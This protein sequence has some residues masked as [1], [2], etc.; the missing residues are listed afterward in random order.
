[1][2]SQPV[3][4]NRV[5][6]EADEVA[7]L[8]LADEEEGQPGRERGQDDAHHHGVIGD[9]GIRRARQPRC[10]SRGC[11]RQ[12]RGRPVLRTDGRARQGT[13]RRD[14]QSHNEAAEQ[15]QSDA[16]RDEETEFPRKNEGCQRDADGNN[17]DTHYD[18]RGD[19]GDE[20]FGI[21]R[22]DALVLSHAGSFGRY[23]GVDCNFN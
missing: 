21:H 5:G 10:D 8:E 7:Q 14:H 18:P 12:Q 19:A 2:I 15:Q 11:D 20:G 16:A 13:E 22:R 4:D 6:D 9:F 17:D 1:V 3:P 23:H